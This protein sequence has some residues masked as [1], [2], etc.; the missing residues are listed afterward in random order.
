MHFLPKYCLRRKTCLTS[1]NSDRNQNV[2]SCRTYTTYKFKSICEG[3][4]DIICSFKKAIF[5]N[6]PNNQ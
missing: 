3:E 2:Y 5:K 6:G 1:T 4:R